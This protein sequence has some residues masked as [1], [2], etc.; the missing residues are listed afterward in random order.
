V[1]VVGI[2]V[3]LFVVRGRDIATTAPA[4]EAAPVEAAEVALEAA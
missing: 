2:L 3:A 4:V 1:G